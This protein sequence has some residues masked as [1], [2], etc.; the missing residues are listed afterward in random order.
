MKY[1]LLYAFVSFA[2]IA[3]SVFSLLNWGL[4]LGIDFRGGIVIEYQISGEF[5]SENATN[6]LSDN[7]IEVGSIQQI[8]E[9]NY[10]FRLGDINQEQRDRIL[11][12][13]NQSGQTAE[14]VRFERVGP[15]IGPELIKKTIYALL[16]SAGAIL[17]WVAL[18]FKSIK[19]GVSAILAMIHDNFILI[20]IFSLLGHFYSAEIDFLFVTALLTTLSFS[21][22]DTIVVYD[23]IREIRKKHGGTIEEVA[24]RA[25]SETM[26]RSIN[27]SA[28]IA[29]MLI[30]LMVFGG[31][32]IFWF[33]AA[34]LTGTIL[35]TYSSP[36]VAVPVLVLWEKIQKK[37]FRK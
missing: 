26:R 36:F 18:Q 8:G 4:T 22:H 37:R 34:L 27:N 12:L 9:N 21:V 33:A 24:N 10:L 35:G 17:G 7:E 14:E 15:S 19:F 23:R 32:T 30:S 20:G 29:L 25:L 6:L 11:E 16:I 28:T 2:L 3:L 1:R 5:S 31:S 13:L